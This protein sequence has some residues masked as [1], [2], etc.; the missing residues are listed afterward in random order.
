[1]KC[2]MLSVAMRTSSPR[3]VCWSSECNCIRNCWHI[4]KRKDEEWKI[5]Q[6]SPNC[7]VSTYR[8]VQEI[9]WETL[10]CIGERSRSYPT[11]QHSSTGS[12][13][14]GKPSDWAL[15]LP[16]WWQRENHGCVALASPWRC[17]LINNNIVGLLSSLCKTFHSTSHEV[18][19]TPTGHM[20]RGK[21][22]VLIEKNVILLSH[23][24]L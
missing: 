4:K 14:S 23:R 6:H 13:S 12:F 7:T 15:Q 19:V 1:M 17:T 5:E 10:L 24:T 20:K 3:T 2:W 16:V 11:P 9:T 21:S 18:F 22:N 8:Y